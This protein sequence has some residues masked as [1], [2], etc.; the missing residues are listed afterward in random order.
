MNAP[1][2]QS[3][4]MPMTATEH[5]GTNKDLTANQEYCCYCYNEGEFAEDLT[6]DEMIER[7]IEFLETYNEQAEQK[8]DKE[9]AIAQMKQYFPTLKRWI[10]S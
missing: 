6:M 4:G 5:F 2:C 1:F 9:Q 3:C 10:A 7:C 8:F